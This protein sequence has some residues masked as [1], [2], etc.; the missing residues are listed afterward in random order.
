MVTLEQ[1]SEDNLTSNIHCS[2]WL[3]KYY[4]ITLNAQT[5]L[6][7]AQADWSIHCFRFSKGPFLLDMAKV[8][9]V[10]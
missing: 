5:S 3:C 10:S 9:A 2:V 1:E 4:Q 8:F 7:S 6:C